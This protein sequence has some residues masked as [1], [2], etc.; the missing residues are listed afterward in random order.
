MKR[1]VLLFTG[2]ALMFQVAQ[3]R[4][5]E[6]MWLPMLVEKLNIG[7]MTEMGLKLSA[8]DIYSINQAC[9]KD[10]IVALDRG[11]CTAEVISEEGLLLTNHHCGYGEI[12]AHS[13]VEHDYLTDG[14]WA[15]S[16]KEELPNHGK[17]ASFLVRAED[18]T[19][20]ILANVS[21]DME[22]AKRHALIDSVSQVIASEA[23][24]DS[25]YRTIVQSMLKGNQFILFVYED[26]MDVRLVG[27]PPESIGKF[28]ADTDNWMWPRHTGDFAMFRVY[29]GPDGKPAAYSDDNVPHKPKSHL[30][31]SLDG[32]KEGDFAM[33]MGYPGTTQRYLSSWGVE[34][35]M[36][37][38]NEFRAEIRGI[39]QDI[40]KEAMDRS[41]EVRIKYASKFARSS[42]YWKYSI[43]QNKGLKALDV[44]GKKKELEKEFS[45]WVNANK[46]RK[47]KYGEAL[48]LIE[49]YQTSTAETQRDITILLE[50]LLIGTE[51]PYFSYRVAAGLEKVLEENPDSTEYIEKF[52]KRSKHT[53]ADFFKDYEASLDQK[54]MKSMIRTFMEMAD[55][56]SYPEFVKEIGDVDKI[57]KYVDKLFKKS[58]FVDQE[59]LEEFI[60]EPDL[61]TLQK[62][63]AFIAG[64]QILNKYRGVAGSMMAKE[65][66]FAKGQR[67]F[68]AGL[69]EMNPDKS[70]YP[71]ANSSM[72]LTYGTVGGYDPKDAV[73][74]KYYTTL[75]GAMAKE[76]PDVR[77]FNVKP[78]LRELYEAKD[79]GRYADENGQ[80][81]VAF[82]TN[83]D[84]TGGNSGSPVM[85]DK[86]QLIGVAFD[87]NWEAMSGDIAFEP[88]LQRTICVD[89]RYVLFVVDK[90]AGAKNLVDEMTIV[91]E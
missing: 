68:V 1:I 91:K 27:A 62:D 15:L 22:E 59:K 17:T 55:K 30:T 67:L 6:G 39:K 90:F 64:K 58:I 60:A 4:A 71:N 38:S 74:Y 36:K 65:A 53:A 26:F 35:T 21:A 20:K 3:V 9:L 48:K 49:D 57:D 78:R 7:E 56:E 43:G 44:V 83:N 72:R 28:G 18:V 11:S 61:K 37:Y 69:M 84:I 10:A 77:E 29:A 88:D 89:I 51:A 34:N 14:F 32:V 2:L 8:E 76:D 66:D 24:G 52:Q 63:P 41:D 54:V 25:H 87:G 75:E 31:I 81:V 19:D 70:Y 42:N 86:G 16:K 40:W 73:H 23:K 45:Q 13:N 5:D 12:Q 46:D 50:T 47:E 79:Y 82:L 80:M 85:N 33:I